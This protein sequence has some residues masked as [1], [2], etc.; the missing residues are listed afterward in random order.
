M[1]KFNCLIAA[2]AFIGLL[3]LAVPIKSQSPIAPT[4]EQGSLE[5][6]TTIDYTATLTI[7]GLIKSQVPKKLS[8][9]T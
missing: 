7:I 3:L 2:I 1:K 4:D 9:K 5:K 8:D 6:V